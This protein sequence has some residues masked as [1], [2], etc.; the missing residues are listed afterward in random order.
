[1]QEQS[2]EIKNKNWTDRREQICDHVPTFHKGNKKATLLSPNPV[3][4]KA[5]ILKQICIFSLPFIPV[6]KWSSLKTSF[7]AFHKSL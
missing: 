7:S 6:H 3:C 4:P 1:M 5:W 2:T